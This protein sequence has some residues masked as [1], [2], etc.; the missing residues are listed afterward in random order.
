MET[1][2]NIISIADKQSLM[3]IDREISRKENKFEFNAK[4]E[5]LHLLDKK[6][7]IY[8][9]FILINEEIYNDIKEDLNIT[10]KWNNTYYYHHQDKDIMVIEEAPQYS[11]FIGNIN[12]IKNNSYNSY[13][14]YYILEFNTISNLNE[15]KK[16]LL[17][18]SN[19]DNYINEKTAFIENKNDDYISPIFS[20]DKMIGYCYK[21]SN[22]YKSCVD[23]YSYL[24]NKI[25]SN[26][27][28]LYF[29]Y[30]RI[31]TK[32]E[33]KISKLEKEKYYL[34]NKDLMKEIK[35]NYNYEEISDLLKKNNI[36]YNDS[37]KN[38]K[39]L[40]LIKKLPDNDLEKY[41]VKKDI[42]EKYKIENNNES[43]LITVK[44]LNEPS[45]NI[46]IY[47]D[48]E[49][50]DKDTANLFFGNINGKENYYLEC[51][52]NYGKIIVHYPDNF[53]G[54]KQ[55]VSIIGKINEEN[56]FITEYILIYNDTSKKNNHLNK[57]IGQL[58]KYLNN[59]QL[60]D[61]YLPIVEDEKK[62]FEIG[63]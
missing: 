47:S 41:F 26:S 52:L 53:N 36:L 4:S 21:Y 23:Y 24:S 12:N 60:Y 39:I 63:V 48:F 43:P 2:D 32:I 15:E 19:I 33:R 61:N 45:K 16:Q 30:Q 20:M 49:L 42:K 17:N 14:I 54:E 35:N 3:E 18:Y 5:E 46:M 31:N 1:L 29:N 59:L 58:D 55:Y 57:I 62:F 38:K 9:E 51:T 7:K 28:E 50:I 37:N 56:V 6:I 22:N 13:I 40:T 25:F 44:N 11:I 27:K 34:I 10:S 8:K